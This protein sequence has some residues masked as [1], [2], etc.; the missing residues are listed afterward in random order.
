[1]RDIAKEAWDAFSEGFTDA[2]RLYCALVMA[3]FRVLSAFINHEPL[4]KL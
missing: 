3:P 1:M 2:L 4:H